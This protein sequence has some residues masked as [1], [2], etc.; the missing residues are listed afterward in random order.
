[1]MRSPGSSSSSS[2]SGASVSSSNSKKTAPAALNSYA[3]AHPGNLLICCMQALVVPSTGTDVTTMQRSGV[4]AQ[5]DGTKFVHDR[6]R[7]AV[8]R[9][10]TAALRLRVYP[11]G[12]KRTRDAQDAAGRLAH[13]QRG[14]R[15]RCTLV[16]WAPTHLQVVAG[17]SS[18]RSTSTL[19]SLAQYNTKN[20]QS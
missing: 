18:S 3:S 8:V 19:I 7:V 16:G 13:F 14:Q 12:V 6:C 11:R 4:L 9:I 20:R 2:S 15:H 5:A 10:V 17:G 1:M